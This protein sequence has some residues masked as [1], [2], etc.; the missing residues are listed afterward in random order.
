MVL[1]CAENR[2]RLAQGRQMA[3]SPVIDNYWAPPLCECF[4]NL[5]T[6]S[7]LCWTNSNKYMYTLTLIFLSINT[8][9]NPM[10]ERHASNCFS[11]SFLYKSYSHILTNTSEEPNRGVI[12]VYEFKDDRLGLVIGHVRQ[13]MIACNFPEIPGIIRQPLSSK[14]TGDDDLAN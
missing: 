5:V 9:L 11:S 6:Q 7:R 3:G 1:A 14:S 13:W 8:P 2:G 10:K 4:T 12:A